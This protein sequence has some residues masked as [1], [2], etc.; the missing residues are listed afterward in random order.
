ML[1]FIFILIFID[2]LLL[3]AV[4]LVQESKGGGLA[5]GFSSANQVMGVKKTADFLERATWSL[6]I[7]L[8]GLCLAAAAIQ[9][10]AGGSAIGVNDEGSGVI[11][12]IEDDPTQ[13]PQVP[14][15]VQQQPSPQ[16]GENAEG[17]Q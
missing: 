6:A 4:V 2:C 3:T 12:R 5:S 11:Q 10:P 1:Y 14:Q 17:N 8:M 16:Q 13:L 15:S 9:G 7:V